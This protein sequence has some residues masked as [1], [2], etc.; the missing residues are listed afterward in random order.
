ME[1]V[2]NDLAQFLLSGSIGFIA[3]LREEGFRFVQAFLETQ[4]VIAR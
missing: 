4:D 1:R 3:D 2:E